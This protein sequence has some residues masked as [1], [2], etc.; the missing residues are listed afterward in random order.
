MIFL[1]KIE[2]GFIK[3]NYFV[4]VKNVQIVLLFNL[5]FKILLNYIYF[6]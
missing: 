3:N 1:I 4:P 5:I 2:I 6:L